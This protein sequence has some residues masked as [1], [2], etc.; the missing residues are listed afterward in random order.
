MCFDHMSK[1]LVEGSEYSTH[2][3]FAMIS[4]AVYLS[5]ITGA[6]SYSLIRNGWTGM[7]KASATSN[8]E[9]DGSSL[10]R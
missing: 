10:P 4:S 1:S 8:N 6:M 7:L 3:F 5:T 2:L 9:R